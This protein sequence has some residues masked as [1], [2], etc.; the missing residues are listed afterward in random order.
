MRP[1]SN[2][3][4][5]RLCA[6]ALL[7]A[8]AL[9]SARA[10]ELTVSA[11]ASLSNAFKELA[12]AFEA[13]HPGSKLLFNFAASDALLAQIARGAPVDV[14]ATAD[15][16]TMDRAEQQKLLQPGSRHNFVANS[17]VLVSPL[18]AGPVAQSLADLAKP[19][20]KRIALGK[21]EGVPA[22]RYSKSALEAAKLWAA[23]EPKAVY[24]QNVRQALDYV[25]RGEV[26]AG[27][28]YATDAAVQ[29]D[30]VKVLFSVP[31]QTPINYPIAAVAAAANAE[32]ARRFIAY[33]MSPAGQAVL[34]R[35]GFQKP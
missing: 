10:A 20:F 5:L 15:Q 25:A 26:E 14:L 13:Q 8:G 11:A 12:P 18:Q 32:D 29:K 30:K 7:A 22:G 2:F 6:V 24:A 23:V 1:S 9:L 35:Y 17:L 21:P 33:V 31:T 3:K 28:V 16:E 19:E 4:T 27:F 34:A